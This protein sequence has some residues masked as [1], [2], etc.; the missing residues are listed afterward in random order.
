MRRILIA[1]ALFLGGRPCLFGQSAAQHPD[2]PGTGQLFVGTCYQPVD[3][4]P[5][6]S[7]R[8]LPS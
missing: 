5:N 7:G 1:S 3:R 2:W 4:S 6:R 8:I